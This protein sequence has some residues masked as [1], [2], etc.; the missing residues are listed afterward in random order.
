L[1]RHVKSGEPLLPPRIS[2]NLGNTI[3]GAKSTVERD[4]AISKF[5]QD[6]IYNANKDND[7]DLNNA[8]ARAFNS[9]FPITPKQQRELG[10]GS[11]IRNR[12][13]EIK[14][15]AHLAN[16]V[17]DILVS[18]IKKSIPYEQALQQAKAEVNNPKVVAELERGGV[19][20]VK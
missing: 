19:L 14:T 5:R 13:K 11:E 9:Q 12:K 8:T 18:K 7:I 3:A 1:E 16:I 6:N 15:A 17:L 20:P 10:M 2:K 4:R